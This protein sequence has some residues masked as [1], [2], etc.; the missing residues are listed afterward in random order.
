MH[1]YLLL[2]HESPEDFAHYSPEEMQQIIMEYRDW[3]TKLAA[4]DRVRGSNKLMDEPGKIL[5]MDQGKLLVTDGPYSETKELI[6][7]YFVISAA[8]YEEAVE[9]SRE[10]PHLK[11]GGRIEVRQVDAMPQE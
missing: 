8:S 5:R 6:G 2:L 10:C 7:G 1:D 11:Y 3:Y 9:I 4:A